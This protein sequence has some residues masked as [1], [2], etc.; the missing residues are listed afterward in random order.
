MYLSLHSAINIAEASPLFEGLR[1]LNGLTS[2]EYQS[3]TFIERTD[4]ADLLSAKFSTCSEF[5]YSL[6]GHLTQLTMSGLSFYNDAFNSLIVQMLETLPHL[7][8]L[9]L[10]SY[11]LPYTGN[12]EMMTEA[13][14]PLLKALEYGR[15][16]K[17]M[18]LPNLEC[19]ELSYWDGEPF[20]G[21]RSAKSSALTL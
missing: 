8:Q 14:F 5:L 13:E 3:N 19:L 12:C 16:D 21:V 6:G 11:R 20:H 7:V 4:S 17:W 9:S 10:Q 18:F 1:C 2:F 15:S